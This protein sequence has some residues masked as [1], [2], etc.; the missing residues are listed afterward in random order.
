MQRVQGGA[1]GAVGATLH[2]GGL[3]GR[4]LIRC[5]KLVCNWF[6]LILALWCSG[7]VVQW[8]SAGGR[9]ESAAS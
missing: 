4:Q 2:I 6:K 8:C 3:E 5:R 1:V 9:A 7:A